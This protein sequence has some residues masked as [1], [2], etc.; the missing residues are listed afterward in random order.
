MR[1]LRCISGGDTIT[2]RRITWLLWKCQCRGKL[3][4]FT[5]PEGIKDY[6]NHWMI[7]LKKTNGMN[8]L[9]VL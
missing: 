5:M 8:P 2:A 1:Y 6:I 3:D 9:M 4:N 7:I